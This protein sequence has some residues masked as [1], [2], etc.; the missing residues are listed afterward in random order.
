MKC[1]F[2]AAL[3][4]VVLFGICVCDECDIVM[5]L[6]E[7][8]VAGVAGHSLAALVP[9]SN[10]PLSVNGVNG[11]EDAVEQSFVESLRK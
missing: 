4:V 10:Y 11:V 1:D 8:L 3:V 2:D 6:S 5:V 9:V 7:H